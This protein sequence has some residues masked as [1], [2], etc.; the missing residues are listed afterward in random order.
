MG[1]PDGGHTGQTKPLEQVDHMN[2]IEPHNSNTSKSLPPD[3]PLEGLGYAKKPS[4]DFRSKKAMD[5]MG[6]TAPPEI[7]KALIKPVIKPMENVDQHNIYTWRESKPGKPVAKPAKTEKSITVSNN[8][9]AHEKAKPIVKVDKTNTC[10]PTEIIPGR[11]PRKSK[12]AESATAISN[13]AKIAGKTRPKSN[14][15]VMDIS[16]AHKRTSVQLSAKSAPTERPMAVS[17]IGTTTS[18][19]IRGIK[20]KREVPIA[21]CFINKTLVD[22]T[23]SMF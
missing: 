4:A 5:R 9:K 3:Q 7:S 6:I 22:L 18:A 20:R 16:E 12:S 14:L 21:L 15:K 1:E 10:G 2:I 11:A 13:N 8:Q 23:L 17:N 19:R